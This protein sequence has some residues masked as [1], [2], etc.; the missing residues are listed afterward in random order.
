MKHAR[1]SSQRRIGQVL[2]MLLAVLAVAPVLYAQSPGNNA[3]YNGSSITWSKSF[4]D[5]YGAS[6]TTSGDFCAKLGAALGT[7]GTGTAGTVVDARGMSVTAGCA[8]D[9]F[10]HLT[11]GL[12]VRVL[13][14]AGTLSMTHSWAI[15]DQS[16]I[17]G[18]GPARTILQA[19]TSGFTDP[20]ASSDT[21]ILHMGKPSIGGSGGGIVFEVRIEHL[22]LDGEGQSLDGIDNQ[23]AEELSYVDDVAINNVDGNGLFLG[24]DPEGKSNGVASH[25]GPYT[26]ITFQTS[27]ATSSTACINVQ[28]SEPRALYG[29]TCIGNA[30]SN[31]AILVDG[32]SVAVEDVRIDGFQDGIRIGSQTGGSDSGQTDLFMN[33]TGTTTVNSTATANLIHIYSGSTGNIT[34]AGV[35][36]AGNNS[37][38]D[39]LTG[40]TLTD[41]HIGT[42]IVGQAVSGGYSR[43][44]TSP[45]LPTWAV[46]SSAPSG[47]CTSNGSLFSNTGGGSG[48]TL[49]ACANNGTSTTWTAVK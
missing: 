10:T 37:I 4:L 36:S 14:P 5:A 33:I 7:L 35:T 49:Y 40:A 39:S 44:T 3:V 12:S 2:A 21:A 6:L 38:L 16:Q 15:P 41:A 32:G 11:S 1:V 42:Y 43:F 48:T 27:S 9:P 23:N 26:N 34:I 20:Y 31:G 19:S 30:S 24:V 25:S 29:V 22:T 28:F 47:T 46:G 13:L 45:A 8:T 18:E 17:V